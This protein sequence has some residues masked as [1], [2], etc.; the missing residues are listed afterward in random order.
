MKRKRLW[1]VVPLVTVLAV[2][3]CKQAMTPDPEPTE[4]DP[5]AP[6]L[7]LVGTWQFTSPPWDDDGMIVEDTLTLTFTPE[8]FIEFNVRRGTDGTIID[9]WRETG[10]WTATQD[11]VTKTYY[12]WDDQNGRRFEEP[13]SVDKHYAWGDE[14]REVLFVHPWGSDDR[15]HHFERG[16]RVN[17]PIPYPLTGAWT[18][19]PYW[20]VDGKYWTF[21]FGDSFTEHYDDGEFIFTL[22]GKWR[23]DEENMF[24]FVTVESASLMIDGVADEDFDASRYEGHE[25][26]Y[27]YAPTGLANTILLAPFGGELR[28]DDA[29]SM[30]VE[31]LGG[32]TSDR[33]WMLLERNP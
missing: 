4:P 26:R 20:D 30:W 9:R 18:G 33:Y 6:K 24:F 16:T 5:V 19:S 7:T 14:A 15:E 1:V 23:L 10:T 21:T 12:Q 3:G 25:L 31:Q 29:T 13:I 8:R 17:D 27:A 11:T 2:L 22:T 32:R 28:Y